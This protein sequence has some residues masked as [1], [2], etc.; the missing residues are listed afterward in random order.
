MKITVNDDGAG[1]T[2]IMDGILDFSASGEFK[3]L[4]TGLALNRGKV[5]TFDL[6]HVSRIDSVG[7]GLL[8]IA[9]EELGNDLRR[10][11]LKSPQGTVRRMLDLTEADNDFDVLP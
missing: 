2:V 4:V 11:R 5:I 7:L 10:V 9:R 6:A 8:H 3:S 1:L